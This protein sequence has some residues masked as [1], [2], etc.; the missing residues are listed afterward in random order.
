[1]LKAKLDGALNRSG[2][3]EAER[4]TVRVQV[5]DFLMSFPVERLWFFFKIVRNLRHC[6]TDDISSRM[7]DLELTGPE[8]VFIQNGKCE[9]VCS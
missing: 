5:H 9:C 8:D 1:M 4:S 7:P 3:S 6:D 2:L